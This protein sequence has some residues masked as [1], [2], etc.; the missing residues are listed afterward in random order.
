MNALIDALLAL[1]RA[2]RDALRPERVDVSALAHAV[3]R[4]YVWLEPD[5]DVEVHIEPG[6]CVWADPTLLKLVLD[7]LLGNAWKYT[8]RRP[9]ARIDVVAAGREGWTG[10]TVKDDGAGFDPAHADGLFKP[11]NR[12]HS[13]HEFAGTGIGLV[14]VQRV[15]QRHGGELEA[16]GRVNEGATFTV[17]LPPEAA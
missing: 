3:L 11:F 9:R 7:N 17:R 10:F 13:S 16:D 5:R 2:G 4:E 12:L 14:T 15:V 1:G 6:L 8:A